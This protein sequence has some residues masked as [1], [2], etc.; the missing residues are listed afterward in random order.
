MDQNH[1][2]AERFEEHRQSTADELSRRTMFLY[3]EDQAQIARNYLQRDGYE[4]PQRAR[5][6]RRVSEW[7][8]TEAQRLGL[9]TV[10]ARPWDTVL[11]R[12][13]AAVDGAAA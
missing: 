11:E 2:L 6:S 5:A 12:V 7:L 1:W 9:P 13:T 10:P 3:E 8:R 4:Q